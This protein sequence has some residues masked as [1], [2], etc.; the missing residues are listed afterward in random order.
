[1]TRLCTMALA[2][3]GLITIAGA[4]D[5][6]TLSSAKARGYVGPSPTS[7]HRSVELGYAKP[8]AKPVPLLRSSH[9]WRK[10]E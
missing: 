8:N 10:H 6:L 7:V 3:G 9:K 4:A 5:T 2:V 1:M